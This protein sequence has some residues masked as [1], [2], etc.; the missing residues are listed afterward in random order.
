MANVK[1]VWLVRLLPQTL[2][3]P[4]SPFQK[5]SFGPLKIALLLRNYLRYNHSSLHMAVLKWLQYSLGMQP[6]IHFNRY[7]NFRVKIGINF[8]IPANKSC[9]GV[10]TPES[11]RSS[12]FRK[13]LM[14]FCLDMLVNEKRKT[15][16][17]FTCVQQKNVINL[18]KAFNPAMFR[19]PK[20]HAFDATLAEKLKTKNPG[21]YCR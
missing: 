5:W 20:V 11:L 6:N 1:I 3:Q 4:P 12:I 18:L 10:M 13:R 16:V 21:F 7:N 8:K 19:T 15:I 2:V 17:F 9:T 14:V